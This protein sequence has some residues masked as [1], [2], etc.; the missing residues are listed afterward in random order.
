VLSSPFVQV[1]RIRDG[2][3][4]HVWLHVRRERALKAAGMDVA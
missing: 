3:I 2:L 4:T 1:F